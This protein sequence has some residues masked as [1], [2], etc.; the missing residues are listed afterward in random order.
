MNS[1]NVMCKLPFSG[2]LHLSELVKLFDTSILAKLKS[3][4]GGLQT[5]LK[6]NRY[7]FKG[8]LALFVKVS[9]QRSFYEFA[10]FELSD[11]F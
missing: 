2:S 11:W 1:K 9:V 5:L 10:S 3:Q 7:I 8:K 4:F 6:N